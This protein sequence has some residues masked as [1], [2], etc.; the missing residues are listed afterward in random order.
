MF[1][2]ANVECVC[3]VWIRHA[4]SN[5][6]FWLNDDLFNKIK[7]NT[8]ILFF[9]SLSRVEHINNVH[10]CVWVCLF[11]VIVC[12]GL[13][14]STFDFFFAKN[15]KKKHVDLREFCSR[16]TERFVSDISINYTKEISIH[17]F[18]EEKKFFFWIKFFVE[19][20]AFYWNNETDRKTKTARVNAIGYLIC[21]HNIHFFSHWW[22]A[23]FN[24][25]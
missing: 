23:H 12:L 17:Y 18:T 5:T 4:Q 22:C 9:L 19:L 16:S 2:F 20:Y 8:N 3:R 15:L 1:A 21:I 24:S 14:I 11:F 25:L 10:P 6:H 7:M 13:L